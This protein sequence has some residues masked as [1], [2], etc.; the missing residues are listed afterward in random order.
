M[1]KFYTGKQI[2]EMYGVRPSTITNNWV[3]KGLKHIRGAGNSFL[4]KK[5]WVEEYIES[6][7]IQNVPKNEIIEF[8]KFKA[9]RNKK[10]KV[11]Y[12]V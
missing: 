9:T 5:E 10:A 12:V 8:N 2:A 3:K 1:D 7:I 11:N 6:Q 4:Y